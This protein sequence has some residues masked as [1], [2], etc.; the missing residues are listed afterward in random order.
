MILSDG[1]WHFIVWGAEWVA[2]F[3]AASC[4]FAVGMRVLGFQIPVKVLSWVDSLVIGELHESV[5]ASGDTSTEGGTKPYRTVLEFE[6]I[7]CERSYS[8]SSESGRTCQKQHRVQKLL[9]GSVQPL[10]MEFQQD[11]T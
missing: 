2:P 6:L 3:I 1:R 10:Y 4:R 8:K 5:E 7:L 11:G 9:L